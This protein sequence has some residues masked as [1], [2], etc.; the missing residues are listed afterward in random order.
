[1]NKKIYYIPTFFLI[2]LFYLILTGS[3]QEFFTKIK[4]LSQVIKLV[5]T[6]YVEEVDM[7]ELIDG[8]IRGLLETLD[9]HSSYITADEFEKINENMKGEF[10]GIGIEFSMLDGYITVIAPISGTPSDRAGLLSGDQIVKINGESAYKIKQDEIIKKLRG[11]KGTQ[12]IVTIKRLGI[13]NFDV[14]LIRDKIPI[15]SVM[16]SFLYNNTTGY[17]NVNRF[18]EKTFE[19]VDT[20]IDS[21]IQSGMEELVLDL[22]GNPGGLMDQA[23]DLLDSFIHS[24]DTLLYT[25]GRIVSAN[26][27]YK[28]TYN[29]KYPNL[30][31]IVLINR[32]SA[33]A[34]EIISGGLQ[35]LDRGIVIGE[36]SFG[37]G[38]VQRQYGLQDGSAV[39]ITIAQYY[40]PTGRLIQRDFDAL[41]EYYLDLAEENREII[42]STKIEF[43]TKGGRIVYGGGGITPDIYISNEIYLTGDAQKL[44]YNPNRLLFKYAN[45]IADVFIPKIIIDKDFADGGRWYNESD[46]QKTMLNKKDL[47][48]TTHFFNW[49]DKEIRSNEDL[50][51]EYNK[52]SIMFNWD[53]INN[54][55]REE[56]ASKLY[57][58]DFKYYVRISEDPYFL[59]ALDNLDMARSLVTAPNHTPDK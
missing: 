49:L 22:R 26:Q 10:E 5:E 20:S 54:K 14:T 8:S 52:D 28:A 7:D 44:L 6:Y 42:D 18:G 3:T 29:T 1:M 47:F 48:S 12:V 46:E 2:A 41:D 19:E 17:I 38:L 34:S 15:N 27:V 11:P 21:L 24:N 4:S 51:F 55:I 16:S 39:R 56:S 50:D 43:K 57:G 37:K 35:D 40:T 31:I 9:P 36:T 58:K 59:S 13:E 45:S 25:S 23:L 33:S 30:P 32:A 53:K